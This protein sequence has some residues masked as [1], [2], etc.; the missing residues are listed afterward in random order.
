M[1]DEIEESNVIRIAAT[2]AGTWMASIASPDPRGYVTFGKTPYTAVVA[3]LNQLIES[4][5]CFDSDPH[6]CPLSNS[7]TS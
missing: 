1:A 6:L 5:Y 3:L 4:G 2:G 7:Q